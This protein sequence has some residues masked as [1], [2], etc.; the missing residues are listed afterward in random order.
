[1]GIATHFWIVYT[2]SQNKN[3]QKVLVQFHD[4]KWADIIERKKFRTASWKWNAK[5]ITVVAYTDQ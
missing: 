2:I 4:L 3:V 5:A 1:M